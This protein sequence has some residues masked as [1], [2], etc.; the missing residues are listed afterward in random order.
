[1]CVFDSEPLFR[2][3]QVHIIQEIVGLGAKNN[4]YPRRG[5]TTKAYLDSDV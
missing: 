1:M 2:M 5:C 4:P 3:A